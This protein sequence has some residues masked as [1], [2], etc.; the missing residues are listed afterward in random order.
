M[1][2]KTSIVV[3]TTAIRCGANF[4]VVELVAAGAITPGNLVKYGA[5]VERVIVTASADLLCLGVADL[6]YNAL[7]VGSP[8]TTAFASGDRVPVIMDGLVCVK[9]DAAIPA[10]TR[11]SVG[12]TTVYYVL[13]E[14]ASYVGIQSGVGRCLTTAGASGDKVVVKLW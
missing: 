1:A 12:T 10:G 3:P 5:G 8:E 4:I 7:A 2:Q 11:V 9:A 14:A 13:T 6:N